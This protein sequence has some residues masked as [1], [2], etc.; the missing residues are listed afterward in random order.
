M[1]QISLDDR[2]VL[3]SDFAV[4]DAIKAALLAATPSYDAK[5]IAQVSFFTNDL[6]TETQGIDLV[7]TYIMDWAGGNTVLSAA[8][9]WNS[10]EIS[11]RVNRGTS[12]APTYFVGAE[13]VHD[14][15]HGAPEY[16]MN[17]TARHTMNNE[18]VVTLRGNMYGPYQNATNN[19]L[20]T[21]SDFSRVV[22]WDGDVTWDL[23]E[24]YR[25]TLGINN[26]F[27]LMPDFDHNNESC[28]GRDIRTDSLQDWQGTQYYVRGQISF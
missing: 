22:Q 12:A 16:R 10:L 28:C 5:D 1:Y 15:E 19:A 14:N 3:S 18:M 7:A 4:T 2:I 8:A 9:N 6:T 23:S 20:T 21:I 24:G 17:L 13:S 26:I 25:L 27:N 11:N